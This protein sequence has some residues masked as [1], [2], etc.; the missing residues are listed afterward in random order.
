MVDNLS[1][2]WNVLAILLVSY[3][4]IVLDISIVITV[5]P[6]IK[7]VLGFSLAGLSWF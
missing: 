6:K 5:L 3:F 7:H 1:R 4:I 2:R